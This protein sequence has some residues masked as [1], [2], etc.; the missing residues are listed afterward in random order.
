MRF[1]TFVTASI[2]TIF[3]G[4]SLA[5]DAT[6]SDPF[7]LIILSSS[8]STLNGTKLAACHEGAA[9]EGLC[10]AGQFTT[11]PGGSATFQHNITT[12][13]GSTVNATVGATGILTFL[14]KGGNF[15][16]SEAMGL[17]VN[18]ASNVAMPLF[19]P[20]SSVLTTYVA[21]DINALMNIQEYVDDRL[22]PPYSPGNENPTTQPYYRWYLCL[23]Y[24]S[25]YTYETLD[26]SLGEAPPQ[27]PTCQAV[28]IKRVFV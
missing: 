27:N 22:P 9:I 25:S 13:N 7:N 4:T 6:A 11:D 20:G 3:I 14:L 16:I 15:N 24:Y 28:Q 1:P 10:W 18:Y 2:A 17:Y 21:F 23:T 19:Y 8:N 5:Q 26:W 12:S